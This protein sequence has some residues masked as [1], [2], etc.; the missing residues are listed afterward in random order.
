[1]NPTMKMIRLLLGSGRVG[2]WR[3]IDGLLTR[4]YG[5]SSL[6]LIIAVVVLSVFWG[7]LIYFSLQNSLPQLI[8]LCGCPKLNYNLHFCYG[9]VVVCTFE[10]FVKPFGPTSSQ[11]L[12]LYAAEGLSGCRR[13]EVQYASMVYSTYWLL[14]VMGNL[15]VLSWQYRGWVYSS[16][17]RVKHNN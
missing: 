17:E 4:G 1:M 3:Q 8:E 11:S 2:N 15:Y 6:H 14:W 7:R 10:P 5:S 16:N 12:V 13:L 9:T